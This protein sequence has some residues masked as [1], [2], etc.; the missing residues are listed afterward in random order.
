MN[1]HPL[2]PKVLERLLKP[3]FAAR[4]LRVR[5]HRVFPHAARGAFSLRRITVV[6]E[7]RDPATR[8]FVAFYDLAIGTYKKRVVGLA[9]SK[10]LRA[11]EYR[12]HRELFRQL[13][14]TRGVASIPKPY[15][16]DRRYGACFLEYIS[17]PSLRAVVK[18]TGDLSPALAQA[19]MEWLAA[20]HAVPPKKIAGVRRSPP[21]EAMRTN[22]RIIRARHPL[23]APKLNH[24]WTSWRRVWQGLPDRAE[25]VAH[26]DFNPMNII[27]HPWKRKIY[28]SVIDF[29]R[30][31]RGPKLWDIAALL[32]QCE[33]SLGFH[34]T[35][36]QIKTIQKT[37]LRA[38]EHASGKLD[39]LSKKELSFFRYYF[40]LLAVT[41][42]LIWGKERDD[43]LTRQIKYL[44]NKL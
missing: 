24:A 19:V 39:D 18:S 26:G 28:A 43:A 14:R 7:Y 29:G 40:D 33:T 5:R 10:K 3:S 15:W 13:T 36:H 35:R 17:G 12:V 4:Y 21:F 38:W 27:I 37:L 42:F 1:S 22:L 20:L 32:S 16:Y 44:M 30:M 11:Y 41:H 23:L 9:H 25:V 8:A 34:L 2:Q 6:K 31:H